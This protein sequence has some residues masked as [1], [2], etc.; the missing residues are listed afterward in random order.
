[1][2]RHDRHYVVTELGQLPSDVERVDTTARALQREVVR[3]EDLQEG[4]L[5]GSEMDVVSAAAG[6]GQQQTA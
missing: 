3:N 5:P 4:E 2:F 6:N 1:M